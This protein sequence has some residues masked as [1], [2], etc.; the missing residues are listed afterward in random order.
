VLT[1]TLAQRPVRVGEIH[2]KGPDP[3][4]HYRRSAW[5]TPYTAIAN[6]TGLPAI[7][8]P[9]VHGEDGLPVGVQLFGRPA[10]EDVLLQ[11][12]TQ[13]EQARPWAQRR[14]ALA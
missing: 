1:P 3:M 8:L 5:F 2:G 10:R 9:L 11:V 13:V 4:D 6:V 12:A 7:S 14:P